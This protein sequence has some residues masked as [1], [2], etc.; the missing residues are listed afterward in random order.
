MR[1]FEQIPEKSL[2]GK[3]ME[4]LERYEIYNNIYVYLESPEMAVD[5]RCSYLLAP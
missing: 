5:A 1:V 3:G 2:I 4:S